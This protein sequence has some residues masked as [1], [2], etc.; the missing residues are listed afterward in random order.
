LAEHGERDP[1]RLCRETL[2]AFGHSR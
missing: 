1:D 2:K